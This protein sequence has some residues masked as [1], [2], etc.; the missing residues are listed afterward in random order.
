[1]PFSASRSFSNRLQYAPMKLGHGIHLAYCTNIHRGESWAESWANLEQYALAVRE[2]VCPGEPYALGLRLSAQAARELAD[3]ATLLAFQR[4]LDQHGCYVFTINGFPFG[5]FHGGRVKEQVYQ[6]DW[7]SRERLDY[8]NQLF[9]LLAE[10]VPPGGEGSVSTLP[11]SFKSF[12]AGQDAEMAMRR[13]LW[14]CVEHIAALSERSGRDLHLGLEPEPLC[15]LETSAESVHF[16]DQLRADRPTDHRVDFHLGLNYD[17]CHFA[18]EFE[19]PAAALARLSAAG[20]RLSK[21]HLSSALAVR[22]N[23]EARRA[24][25]RFAEE[26][27]LHQVVVRDSPGRFRRYR[28]LPEAL[29]DEPQSGAHGAEW[30]IHFHIP[31]HAQ[32]MAP[33]GT[34]VPHLLGVLDAVAADPARCH[35]FE[36]ETYT[37][38]VMP[39][40]LR[41]QDVVEQLVGEYHWTLARFRERGLDGPADD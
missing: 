27:Y 31:L 25:A 10:L 16:F 36:M 24:L 15:Y 32:P 2:R 20:I 6:P 9:D 39:P 21:V 8:T 38:D 30:R 23:A 4:W 41:E 34:T 35:H 37:W 14:A 12:V 18:V 5:R 40:A 11:G 17:T 28:D 1:M 22:P 3:H 19:D 7:T 29:N 26:T 33:L 13:N